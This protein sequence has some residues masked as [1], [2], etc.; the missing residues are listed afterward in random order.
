MQTIY[1]LQKCEEGKA[2][3]KENKVCAPCG[4]TSEYEMCGGLISGE[5]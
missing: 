1:C 3:N 2:P 5:L 4:F